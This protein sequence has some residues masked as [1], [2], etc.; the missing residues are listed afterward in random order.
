[1]ADFVSELMD[2]PEFY[3]EAVKMM[4]DP[5][6][7]RKVTDKFARTMFDH[8]SKFKKDAGLEE[9]FR[10]RGK[11]LSEK[12]SDPAFDGDIDLQDA[13]PDEQGGLPDSGNVP[14]QEHLDEPGMNSNQDD[15]GQMDAEGE[16]PDDTIG[17]GLGDSSGSKGKM[18][19]HGNM[20]KSVKDQ[21]GDGEV[22]KHCF[23][24]DC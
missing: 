23:G 21:F 2:H 15:M 14:D 24:P 12:V 20:L 5:E 3:D 10:R 22:K 8:H 11:L 4:G 16:Q 7:G 17:D 6:E 19:A 1:M 9:C 18:P 13:H